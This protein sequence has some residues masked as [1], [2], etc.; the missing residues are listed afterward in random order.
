MGISDFLFEAGMLKQLDRSGWRTIN[1]ANCESVAEHSFRTALIAYVLAKMEKLSEADELKLIKSC[2]LHDLH[3][4]RTGDINKLNCLYVQADE[5]R[6]EKDIFKGLAFQKDAE[7]SLLLSGKLSLLAG[8]ADKL[9]VILQAKE[10]H[11][12]GNKYAVEWIKRAGKLIKTPSGKKLLQEIMKT[13]SKD[14]LFKAK[15][16]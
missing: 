6:A 7:R 10:Y 12:L 11:E 3:E 15:G 14:W 13:G 16:K 9:E 2:L 8:D 1:I 5:K 4:T